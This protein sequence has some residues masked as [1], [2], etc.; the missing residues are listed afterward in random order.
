MFYVVLFL[1]MEGE[2]RNKARGRRRNRTIAAFLAA[3]TK[4]GTATQEE[5]GGAE[6]SERDA[7][8]KT[9]FLVFAKAIS[10]GEWSIWCSRF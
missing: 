3:A 5:S 7:H 6:N 8:T 1:V 10:A 2:A 9:D 4:D